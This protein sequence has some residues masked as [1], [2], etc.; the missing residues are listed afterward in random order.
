MTQAH[1]DA[2][3]SARLRLQDEVNAI[4]RLSEMGLTDGSDMRTARREAQRLRSL[5]AR[6]EAKPTPGPVRIRCTNCHGVTPLPQE[7][8]ACP[9]CKCPRIFVERLR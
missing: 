2:L 6:L 4:T 7:V 3:T 9:V 1:H 8:N 5:I